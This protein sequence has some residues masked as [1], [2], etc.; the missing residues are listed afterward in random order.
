M[1]NTP[2]K[3]RRMSHTSSEELFS[4]SNGWRRAVSASSGDKVS[5]RNVQRLRVG[6]VREQ[7]NEEWICCLLFPG[8]RAEM[9]R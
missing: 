2:L 3:A 7:V 4:A 8:W 5:V 9:A 1:T 6:S